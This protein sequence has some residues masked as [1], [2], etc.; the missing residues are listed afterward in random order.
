MFVNGFLMQKLHGVKVSKKAFATI[1]TKSLSC[2]VKGYFAIIART[3]NEKMCSLLLT[4]HKCEIHT[5][6]AADRYPSPQGEGVLLKDT[7]TC[8]KGSELNLQLSGPNM[9]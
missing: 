1:A 7:A 4:H 5:S 8:G 9:S 2:E 6:G 3:H